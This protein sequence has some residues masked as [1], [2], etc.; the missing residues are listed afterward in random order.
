VPVVE[1]V[2]HLERLGD[3][4]L[5]FEAAAM[6]QTYFQCGRPDVAPTGKSFQGRR[7]EVADLLASFPLPA[8]GS[9]AEGAVLDHPD[10]GRRNVPA[11]GPDCSNG[12]WAQPGNTGFQHRS[13]RLRIDRQPS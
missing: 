3:D 8:I 10:R 4:R 7:A 11:M 13:H 1:L 6:R 2:A 5:E 9:I 12:G